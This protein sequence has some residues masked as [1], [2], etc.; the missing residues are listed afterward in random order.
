MSNKP[1]YYLTK[2]PMP[3]IEWVRHQ[4][5]ETQALRMPVARQT[6]ILAQ[7]GGL[8]LIEA[9]EKKINE[10]VQR[11][12]QEKRRYTANDYISMVMS[13]AS[14]PPSDDNT[15]AVMAFEHKTGGVPVTMHKNA[16][17]RARRKNY[18]TCLSRISPYR[19]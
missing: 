1:S 3:T 12:R 14:T 11:R 16:V 7:N 4:R 8:S 5:K 10:A 13:V 19:A 17:K 6:N 15:V 2:P 18:G 9:Q